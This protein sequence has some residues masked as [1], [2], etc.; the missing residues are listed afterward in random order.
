MEYIEF[1]SMYE[2][3]QEMKDDLPV[4]DPDELDAMEAALMAAPAA[5][6]A[7]VAVRLIRVIITG[8]Y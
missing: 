6:A 7:P 5:P 1:D 8:N 3:D 2:V 4:Q